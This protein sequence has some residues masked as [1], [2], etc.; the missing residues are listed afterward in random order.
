[1]FYEAEEITL[2]GTDADKIDMLDSVMTTHDSSDPNYRLKAKKITVYPE[3]KIVFRNLSVY[4]GDTRV[5]WLPYLSQPLDEEL[6][7]HWLPGFRTSWGAFLLNRYG[8]MIGD[9]TLAT[10]RLDARSE[11]GFAGGIDFKS[12]RHAENEN[13]GNFRVYGASDSSPETSRNGRRPESR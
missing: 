6:G 3:D 11:R 10:L 2:M 8:F 4:A 1:M 12:M 7:Y 5:F 13:F 9:H